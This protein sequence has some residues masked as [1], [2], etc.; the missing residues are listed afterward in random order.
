M[1]RD[2]GIRSAP[3]PPAPC[4]IQGDMSG[5]LQ[6]CKDIDTHN[7]GDLFEQDRDA[8][9]SLFRPHVA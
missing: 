2:R 5:H 4:D 3:V 8:Q 7:V 9:H 1:A 6:Q